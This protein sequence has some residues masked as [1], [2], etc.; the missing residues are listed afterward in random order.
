M[1]LKS[2]AITLS[3]DCCTSTAK[4]DRSG[5]GACQVDAPGVS[6]LHSEE[7]EAG[8]TAGSDSTFSPARSS[9]GTEA[10]PVQAV[11]AASAADPAQWCL[12]R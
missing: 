12:D 6:P 3:E 4:A 1:L 8:A 2:W 11:E 10:S 5:N 7:G 9:T